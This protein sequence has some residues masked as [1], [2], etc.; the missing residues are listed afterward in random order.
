MARRRRSGTR[1]KRCLRK[2]R[3]RIRGGG[4]AMRCAK[5]AGR[6]SAG[7]RSRRRGRRRGRKPAG[8]AKRGSRCTRF[9]RVRV[10]RGGMQRRC[11][12]FT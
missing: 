12:K 4:T 8:M 10:R 7:K 6:S 9:K 1:G 5:F 2:K 11:V 3:V